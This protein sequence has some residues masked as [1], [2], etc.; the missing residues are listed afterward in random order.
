TS[1]TPIEKTGMSNFVSFCD[2]RQDL[3]NGTRHCLSVDRTFQDQLCYHRNNCADRMPFLC[4]TY[5]VVS[6]EL[7][8]LL[9]NTTK[10]KLDR[11]LLIEV[12]VNEH[13][14]DDFNKVSTPH[15]NLSNNSYIMT[16][17]NEAIVRP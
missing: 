10:D 1:V 5:P 7:N 16:Q 15:F 17:Q 9:K 12:Q 6:V 8:N 13:H 3:K 2:G 11:Q 4:F 14:H